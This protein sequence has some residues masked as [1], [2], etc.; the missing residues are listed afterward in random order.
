M[1]RTI[2]LL[3]ALCCVLSLSACGASSNTPFS[4]LADCPDKETIIKRLG[5]PDIK[6][7]SSSIMYNDYLWEGYHGKLRID[8]T[9]IEGTDSEGKRYSNYLIES[10]FWYVPS[11]RGDAENL[12]NKIKK[13]YKSKFDESENGEFKDNKGNCYYLPRYYETGSSMLGINGP[14]LYIPFFS[15]FH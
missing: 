11:S 7:S 6:S 12:N 2:C 10:A 14:Y 9:F 3:L 5:E 8:F 15:K 13:I 1:K 4:K